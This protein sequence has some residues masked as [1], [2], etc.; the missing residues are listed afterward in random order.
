MCSSTQCTCTHIPLDVY[1]DRRDAS[2]ARYMSSMRN[3]G[4]AHW[5]VMSIN[6]SVKRAERM[7]VVLVILIIIMCLVTFA[8]VID[9]VT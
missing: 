1:R 6:K 9:Q 2:R 3:L 7:R 4:Y 8:M 5:M